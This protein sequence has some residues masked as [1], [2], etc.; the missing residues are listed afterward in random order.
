MTITQPIF[1]FTKI[2]AALWL[3]S[4]AS[5]FVQ[6]R[7]SDQELVSKA[8]Q[9]M[10]NLAKLD[11][12]SGAVLI[13]RDGRVLLSRGYGMADLEHDVP[14]APTTKFRIGSVTK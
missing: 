7:I 5:S 4:V 12:F 8:S 10:D 14:N 11:Y 13:A 2:I 1:P 6:T 9:Y 3:L